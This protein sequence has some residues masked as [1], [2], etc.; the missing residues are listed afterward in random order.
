MGPELIY[1]YE[2]TSAAMTQRYAELLAIWAEPGMVI[3]LQGELG[4]GKTTFTQGFARGLGIQGVV[5]SPTFTIVKVH[6][7]GR[8]PLYHIDAY[9]LANSEEDLGFE[10][11]FYGQGVSVVEWPQYVQR[12]LPQAIL[13]IQLTI[14]NETQRKFTIATADGRLETLLRKVDKTWNE[15]ST[16]IPPSVI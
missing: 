4:A 15:P 2:M 5:N 7:K 9:R 16:S 10:E 3:T 8:M 13:E 6:R 12:F 11:F 1:T 14:I